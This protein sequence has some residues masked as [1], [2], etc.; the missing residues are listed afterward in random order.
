[1]SQERLIG[2]SSLW[3]GDLSEAVAADDCALAHC[4]A[5]IHATLSRALRMALK[6]YN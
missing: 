5:V 4:V 2:H 3:N 1:M 6:S